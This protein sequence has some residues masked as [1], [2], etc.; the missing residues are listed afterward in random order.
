MTSAPLWRRLAAIAYDT[1]LLIA[2]WFA[3]A[4]LLLLLSGGQLTAPDR[5]LWLLAAEQGALVA[6]TWGF[7]VWF[8]THGGQTLGMRAWRLKLVTEYGGPV[9][10]PAA[11]RRLLAA[12]LSFGAAGLGFIWI[13]LDRERCA[14]HDR[15]SG[16]R[17]IVLPK[18][19][20]GSANPS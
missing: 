13:L 19:A 2:L 17:V 6:V 9:S 1:L 10:L 14:W 12:V 15:L 18:D 3:T 5:P 20:P 8:W 4:A 11:N 7:F 16:T